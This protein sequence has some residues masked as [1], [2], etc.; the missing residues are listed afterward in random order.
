MVASALRV[1]GI[2]LVLSLLVA[3]SI[4]AAA[5]P[6]EA[7]IDE[8]IV[9]LRNTPASP[10]PALA[11]VLDLRQSDLGEKLPSAWLQPGPLRVFLLDAAAL[12]QVAALL[13]QRR[14]ANLI[15]LTAGSLAQP[16]SDVSVPMTTSEI[17]TAIAAIADGADVALLADP[18]VK[19]RRFDEASLVR[20]HQGESRQRHSDEND[21]SSEPSSEDDDNALPAD[22]MLERAV[23]LIRGLRALGYQ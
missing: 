1:L 11:A 15:F 19:K 10:P 2:H 4:Q 17:T 7:Q 12:R 23:Q 18:P 20:R 9:Y 22:P 13:E 16:E 8:T 21:G 14:P 3:A 5:E 6:I